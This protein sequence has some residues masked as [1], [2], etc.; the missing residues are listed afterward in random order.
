[1]LL[2]D[3]FVEGDV[4][5]R[6]LLF[7]GGLGTKVSHDLCFPGEL[8]EVLDAFDLRSHVLLYVRAVA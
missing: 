1:M 3:D 8:V 6:H 7:F 2:L 5:K 4:L